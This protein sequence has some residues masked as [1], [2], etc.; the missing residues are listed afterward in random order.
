MQRVSHFF[1]GLCN[2]HN[3]LC[4]QHR[5]CLESTSHFTLH[6]HERAGWLG[7]TKIFLNFL[8]RLAQAL[9]YL[10]VGTYVVPAVWS[11]VSNASFWLKLTLEITSSNTLALKWKKLKSRIVK[12]L[13][14][15]QIAVVW[16]IVKLEPFQILETRYC[17]KNQLC[18]LRTS[19]FQSSNESSWALKN[20]FCYGWDRERSSS[21]CE[22][23]VSTNGY[24][25]GNIFGCPTN[26][27][28]A[29]MPVQVSILWIRILKWPREG[30]GMTPGL[31]SQVTFPSLVGKLQSS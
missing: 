6:F 23:G 30:A 5:Y 13:S 17:W 28:G 1:L 18:W 8:L 25:R 10:L 26:H 15:C 19:L 2:T 22:E 24:T 31:L 9:H 16:S 11:S 12:E 29:G 14:Q 4:H 27:L 21:C 7:C 20:P 3:Q